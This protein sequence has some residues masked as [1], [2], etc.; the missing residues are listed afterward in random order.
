MGF[1]AGGKGLAVYDIS[2]PT[3]PS[4]LGNVI[5]TGVLTN[6]GGVAITFIGDRMLIAGSKGLVAYDI[7][8]PAS[9]VRLGEVVKTGVLSHGSEC[10][11]GAG[12]ALAG[13]ALFIVGGKGVA[14]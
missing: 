13:N 2:D 9:P 6:Q 12:I 4:R 3:S 7:S 10:I 5:N 11:G 14:V 1:V 8:S